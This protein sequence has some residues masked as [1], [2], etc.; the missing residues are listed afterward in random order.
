MSGVRLELKYK[1]VDL[2]FDFTEK[3]AV[4]G[5][6]ISPGDAAKILAEILTECANEAKKQL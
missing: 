2:M 4:P 6:G 1:I 5:S 3:Y